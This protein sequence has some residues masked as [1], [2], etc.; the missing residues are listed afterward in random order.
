[1]NW[2]S[3]V[4]KASGRPQVAAG[5]RYEKAPA[6]VQPSQLGG[7]N[8]QP[9]ARD[10]Q[11]G[12]VF[13][14][15]ME[16]TAYMVGDPDFRFQSGVWNTGVVDPPMAADPR[17]IAQAR[18]AYRGF[19]L[20]WDPVAQRE[21]WRV[22]HPGPWN[23]GVLATAGGLV[24]QGHN[25]GAFNAYD[26]A[27]GQQLWSAPIRLHALG[28]PITYAID[29]EQYVAVAAGFGSSLHLNGGVLMPQAN[30]P[31]RGR[32]LVFRL[33]AGQPLPAATEAMRPVVLPPAGEL[34]PETVARGAAQRRAVCPLLRA[35]PRRRR[36]VRRRAAGSAQLALPAK[37]SAV[38][39]AAARRRPEKARHAGFQ[40]LSE[41]RRH[42]GHPQLPDR[43][44]PG[45]AAGRWCHG[46]GA[47]S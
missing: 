40:C 27:S 12:L 39:P 42:R 9:M 16:S 21:V 8:W 6:L 44:G 1:M 24:F 33:G 34:S 3:H 4:D 30:A 25:G 45:H 13:I 31:E 17:L 47:V 29:G 37:R 22:A 20:A 23:G 5:A 18:Q 43:H 46:G 28:G 2:A 11:T 36:C 15:A 7:H 41:S 38:S 19:L 26:S 35:V 14:P 32:V 10:P